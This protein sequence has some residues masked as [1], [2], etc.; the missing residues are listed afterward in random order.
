MQNK[1]LRSLNGS[2]VKDQIS[3]ASLLENFKM[4]AVNQL[5]A[6][7]K[8]LEMWKAINVVNYPL[9]IRKQNNYH[10]GALTRADN[11]NRPLE[12]GKSILTHNTCISDAIRLW[13]HAPGKVKNCLS[14]GQAK[15]EI[16]NFVK[17]LPI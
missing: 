3:T 16:K 13:N 5:N 7:I 11:L 6:Q 15:R 8:L 14:V 1:L 10:I 2:Q 12:I 17:T 4:L 9:E